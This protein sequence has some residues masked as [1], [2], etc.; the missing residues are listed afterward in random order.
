MKIHVENLFVHGIGNSTY[1]SKD[2]VMLIQSTGPSFSLPFFLAWSYTQSVYN[3][4]HQEAT[5]ILAE[6]LIPLQN[7]HEFQRFKIF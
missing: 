1:E 2:C 5:I 4:L 7:K 6:K 3:H